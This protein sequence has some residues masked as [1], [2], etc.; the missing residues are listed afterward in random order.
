MTRIHLSNINIWPAFMGWAAA[1]A[2][3]P[4]GNAPRDIVLLALFC[5]L[6]GGS[7]FIVNDILDEEGDH[8]TAPYLPLPAGIIT[9][10]ASWAWAAVYLIAAFVVLGFAAHTV[11]RFML[12]LGIMLGAVVA[13][14][15][16]SKVK[17][18]GIVASVM[19][20]IPQTVPAV[21]AWIFASG[22]A[23]W[24]LASIICY[25]V[26]ACISNN[27]L[28]A[29]RDVDLDASVGNMTVAIRLGAPAAYRLAA[30]LG[31]ASAIPVVVSGI[32]HGTWWWL[33]F[34]VFG[35]GVMAANYG[36]TYRA[37][38]EPDRGRL[39]RM[40]DMKRFKSGEFWRHAG[41][42]AV[43]SPV[44]ALI[45][46]AVMFTLLRGGGRVYVKRVVGGGIRRQQ[47]A[48]SE[49]TATTAGLVAAD[50]LERS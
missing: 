14:V 26:L 30:M 36:S 12:A 32:V 20:T 40:A 35:L 24:A 42:V 18:D 49:G 48:L 43:F 38:C 9:R 11:P 23:W 3:G 4:G 46:G 28:A 27:I 7:L 25:C 1:E 19:V 15:A 2:T 45:A 39:T 47:Q 34:E 33:P 8:V 6:S 16:Y 50:N 10:K 17:D 22:G 41:M 37:M 44:T 13:S 29:L 5:A 31:F 21:I